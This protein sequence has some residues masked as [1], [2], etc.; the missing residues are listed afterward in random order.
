VRIGRL[1]FTTDF[2]RTTAATT[3]TPDSIRVRDL[4]AGASQFVTE[5]DCRIF[6]VPYAERVDENLNAIMFHAVIAL[7]DFIELHSVLHTGATAR[8]HEDPQPFVPVFRVFR[9]ESP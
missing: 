5:I 8:F 6:Q 7:F 1:G 9:D 2:E 4:K 3:P